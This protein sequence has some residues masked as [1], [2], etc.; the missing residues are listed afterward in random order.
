MPLWNRAA[1]KD[2]ADAECKDRKESDQPDV[3]KRKQQSPDEYAKERG[4]G[5]G[6]VVFRQKMLLNDLA[7]THL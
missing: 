7:D 3:W 1:G 6:A 4:E 2:E 5:F